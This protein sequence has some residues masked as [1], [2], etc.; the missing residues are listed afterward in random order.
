MF[1]GQVTL[2]NGSKHNI[3]QVNDVV[4]VIT[5]LIS[6]VQILQK[7]FELSFLDKETPLL[8]LLEERSELHLQIFALTTAHAHLSF[9]A[10]GATEKIPLR[11]RNE[12][13]A[14]KLLNEDGSIPQVVKDVIASKFRDAHARDAVSVSALAARSE[15]SGFLEQRQKSSAKEPGAFDNTC[16]FNP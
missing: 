5:Q 1:D 8:K 10:T 9:I 16:T 14:R 15:Y 4:R 6:D 11:A 7:K 3:N 12:F 13:I 2:R